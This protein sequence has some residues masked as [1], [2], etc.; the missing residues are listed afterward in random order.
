METRRETE[1]TQNPKIFGNPSSLHWEGREAR[2][3]LEEARER[4]AAAL[5]VSAKHLY[6]TSGGT[7]SNAIALFS[8]LT[9]REPGALLASAVE[10][11]SILEN[12]RVLAGLDRRTALINVEQDGRVSPACLEKA[13]ARNPDTRFVAIM[14][15]N[16]ETGAL[17][18][19]PALLRLIRERPG[20]HVHSDLVQALGKVPLAISGLDSGSISAHKLGGP[21]GA[22]LLFLRKAMRPL[23]TGGG[24]EGGIRPG[25]ENTAGALALAECLEERIT[26]LD[27]EYEKAAAR[28]RGLIGFLRSIDGCSLIPSDRQVE[29][30]RF[31]PY[32]LQV[33]FRGIPGEVMAR[34]L[35]D[36]GFA[37]S[38]GSACSSSSKKRP[39]LSAMGLDEAR[40]LEGIRIS[41]GWSTTM[42]E[43]DLLCGAIRYI[44][45]SC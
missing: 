34:V 37:V 22:G 21:R 29:D 28:F 14:A 8:T 38:T 43:I 23:Y 39:I 44:V 36:R 26:A 18:D 5:K 45:V 16:N 1:T 12:C 13:L 10:H 40:S 32:I 2:K 15:V 42:E 33:A 27:A 9:R 35:D 31:S 30:P 4:C 19:M 25:T 17:M 11:P 6:F 3:A 24:Q 41:Q 7:E 20:I